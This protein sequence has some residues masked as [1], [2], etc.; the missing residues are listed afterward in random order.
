MC[1]NRPTC[2]ELLH[3]PFLL[4]AFVDDSVD[5]EAE[6][7][8]AAELRDIVMA[9]HQH[10]LKIKHDMEKDSRDGSQASSNN[11]SSLTAGNVCAGVVDSSV[12]RVVGP[13]AEEVATAEA[14]DF[15]CFFGNLL[16]VDVS[17]VLRNIMLGT[18]G[19][20]GGDEGVNCEGPALAVGISRVSVDR[21]V[22]LPP[23]QPLSVVLAEHGREL[24]EDEMAEARARMAGVAQQLGVGVGRAVRVVREACAE[25]AHAASRE[26]DFAPTPKAAHDRKRLR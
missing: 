12:G 1:S 15:N 20:T 13:S 8:G 2:V 19:A 25:A 21:S 4:K 11:N 5:D 18:F 3:H 22:P 9:M 7:R 14:A 6:Q 10:L 26:S 17:L 23:Q 16:T 24:D